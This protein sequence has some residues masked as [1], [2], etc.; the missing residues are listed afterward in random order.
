MIDNSSKKQPIPTKRV[1]ISR[2]I[3]GFGNVIDK[4]LLI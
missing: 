4:L 1:R 3:I 2:F